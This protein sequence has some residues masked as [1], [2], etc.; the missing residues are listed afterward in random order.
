[1]GKHRGIYPIPVAVFSKEG[2]DAT[3]IDPESLGFGASGEEKSLF[4]CSKR[5]FDVN[6]DGQ[7]DMV[8]F[9]DAYKAGFEVGDVEG[10][11]TG[12]YEHGEFTSR[13]PLKIFAISKDKRNKKWKKRK[14]RGHGEHKH[15][16]R[17]NRHK[18]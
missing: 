2:F 18:H 5:G 11:L 13:A 15:H 6:R 12:M 1:M 10:V 14:Y 7:R 3:T 8:C 16:S 9:F 17:W 4:R